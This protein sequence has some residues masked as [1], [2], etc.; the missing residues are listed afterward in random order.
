MSL[1]VFRSSVVMPVVPGPGTSRSYN[2]KWM[3]AYCVL[4]SKWFISFWKMWNEMKCYC[5]YQFIMFIIDSNCSNCPEIVIECEDCLNYGFEQIKITCTIID[6]YIRCWIVVFTSI[7]DD[8]TCPIA[9][10]G[11][12]AALALEEEAVPVRLGGL[13]KWN[14]RISCDLD[15]RV[16]NE[17]EIFWIT[18][19]C[20]CFENLN[21]YYPALYFEY[22]V[23]DK[24]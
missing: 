8:I 19:W 10:V 9:N 7:I 3:F 17:L 13:A 4:Q 1:G 18:F 6:L 20:N 5:S 24:S 15:I 23:F 2:N 14:G 16:R 12:V 22:T 21:S 11:P